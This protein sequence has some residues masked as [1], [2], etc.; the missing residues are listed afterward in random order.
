[1]PIASSELHVHRITRP[2][3]KAANGIVDLEGNA[4]R[5]YASKGKEVVLIRPD[6][7]IALRCKI[8]EISSV[9]DYLALKL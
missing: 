4:Y 3:T 9:A 1:M 5:A 6:G 8:D 7:Y 2:E